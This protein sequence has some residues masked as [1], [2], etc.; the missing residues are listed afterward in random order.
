M[1]N[2]DYYESGITSLGLTY[3]LVL[4]NNPIPVILDILMLLF[5]GWM[6]LSGGVIFVVEGG[7]G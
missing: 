6:F 7:F 4:F 1:N 2:W 5:F 3:L